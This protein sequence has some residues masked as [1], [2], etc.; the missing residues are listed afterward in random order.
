MAKELETYE[1]ESNKVN[2]IN[3]VEYEALL[4]GLKV[5]K[6]VGVRNILILSDSQLI[7]DQV[8]EEFQ[9]R[10]PRIAKYLSQWGIDLIGPLPLG[11]GQTKFAVVAVDYFTKWAEAKALATITEKKV[12]DFIWKNII[13]RFRI[14]YTIINDNGKQ[15]D[16]AAFREFCKELG[17]KHICSSPA[18]PQAN[19]QV[20]AVNKIIK[21]T[22]KTRL[23]KLKGLWAEELPNA[24][25]A[26]RTT[27]CTLTGETPFS[28]SFG[29]EAVVLVEIGLPSP[30]VEQFSL[31]DN[32]ASVKLNL[33][34]LEEHRET[35]RLRMAKYKIE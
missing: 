12:T 34:L 14:P 26:Y 3:E 10:E 9:A 19:G 31:L 13:Y 6:Y 35:T 30:R 29:S 7:V 24:L 21:R 8:K 4:A 33:D 18:H 2:S 32:N 1:N 20:E 11:K 22:L 23:E 27:P 15:F 16:T 17:I 5:V 25:W 28:L